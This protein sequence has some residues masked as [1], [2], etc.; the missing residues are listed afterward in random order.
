[1]INVGKSMEK[2][3]NVETTGGNV[4]WFSYY[5]KQEDF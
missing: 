3:D 2:G 5:G 1:M 4:D